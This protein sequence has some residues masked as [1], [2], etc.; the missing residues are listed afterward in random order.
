MGGLVMGVVGGLVTGPP[1][2]AMACMVICWAC[3]RRNVKNK[4]I[5]IQ[6]RPLALGVPR[7]AVHWMSPPAK[8]RVR[9]R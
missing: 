7:A 6:R 2:M 4:L 5:R 8:G 9:L 3:E 1:T